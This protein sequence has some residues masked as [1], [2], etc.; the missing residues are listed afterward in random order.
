MSMPPYSQ[1]HQLVELIVLSFWDSTVILVHDHPTD[2]SK[3][4]SPSCSL[5]L[6]ITRTL[7]QRKKELSG[8]RNEKKKVIKFMGACD[9][10]YGG[11]SAP[12]MQ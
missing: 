2:M 10:A 3:M 8:S 7:I 6:S 1:V 4:S 9:V 5:I 12:F 11:F